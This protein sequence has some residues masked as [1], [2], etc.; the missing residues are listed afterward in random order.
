[1]LM[2]MTLFLEMLQERVLNS[3]NPNAFGNYFE[4]VKDPSKHFN[5]YGNK[6]PV[7][8]L[9]YYG[10]EQYLS[11]FI[12]TVLYK[13]DSIESYRQQFP[14]FFVRDRYRR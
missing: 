6:K 14:L 10:I 13:S 7:K 5:I 9:L 2:A 1:M 11:Y 3:N 12:N 8:Q 4:I